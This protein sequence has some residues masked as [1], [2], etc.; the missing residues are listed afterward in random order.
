MMR[1]ITNEHAPVKTRT[2]K[3]NRLPYMDGELRQAINVKRMLKRKH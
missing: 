2:L 3:G 1:D